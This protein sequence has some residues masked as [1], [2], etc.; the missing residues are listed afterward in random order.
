MKH[1]LAQGEKEGAFNEL[2]R[3]ADALAVVY[4]ACVVGM[5]VMWHVD[6]SHV[7]RAFDITFNCL[8][9]VIL[10]EFSH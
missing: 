6:R 9:R 2:T 1:V 10:K 3:D 4:T 7:G 8:K 5:G